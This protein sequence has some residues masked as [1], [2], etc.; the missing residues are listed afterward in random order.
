MTE[1]RGF[2]RKVLYLT[3]IAFLL[4]PLYYMSRPAVVGE[5]GALNGG[6]L[7]QLRAEH[8][9]SQSNIGEI[10]PAGEAIKLAM[11][12][13]RGVAA[14]LLWYKANEAKKKE[15][16]TTAKA[17]AEQI[18][19]LEPNFIGV[20]RFQA[21]NLAYNFSVEFDDYHYRYKWVKDGIRYLMKA[22]Q[23][24]TND[25][26]LFWD[27]GMFIARKIGRADEHAE[28]RQL[29][30]D[31]DDF[32]ANLP[33]RDRDNWLVGRAWF[34]KGVDLV[35]NRRAPLRGLNPLVYFSDPALCRM[36]YAEMLEEDGGDDGRGVFGERAK[37]AWIQAG[38][39]WREFGDRDIRAV[40]NVVL[41]L[42]DMEEVKAR[43]EEALAALEALTPPDAHEKITA[44]KRASL[45][46]K[47]L[48]AL[49]TPADER[50]EDQRS[51]MYLVRDKLQI[52]PL[53]LAERVDQQHRTEAFRL[54]DDA[55]RN[56]ALAEQIENERLTVNYDYWKNRPLMEQ[57]D[58]CIAAHELIYRANEAFDSGQEDKAPDL[59][60][61][62][63][64]KWRLA[65]DRYP[66]MKKQSIVIDELLDVIEKY[67]QIVAPLNLFPEK[68]ILQDIVD[69]DAERRL[70]PLPGKADDAAPPAA[71]ESTP[72]ATDSPDSQ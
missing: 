70:G 42:N 29:F 65:L 60:D 62:A 16:W 21:W 43:G 71:N 52:K 54:A 57:D 14:N 20:W 13:M 36:N 63:F 37:E 35:V 44:E 22:V 56:A 26:R 41:R 17:A 50:D 69:Q 39:A 68:F 58:D 18:A 25:T 49:E 48:K 59:Y 40:Y 31:D 38:E 7:A 47:E 10:D 11:L 72:S 24:N 55:T 32:H 4:L 27:I 45:S 51:L 33:R 53:D 12:G 15:D 34:L 30:R 61:Q 5:D 64:H 67:R 1:R 9:L 8:G 19:L 46:K 6:R 3:A 66:E 2:Q 23:Y 28:Y